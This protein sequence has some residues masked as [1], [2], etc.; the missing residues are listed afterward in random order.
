MHLDFIFFLTDLSCDLCHLNMP[1]ECAVVFPFMLI[2]GSGFW[3]AWV[4][5][6]QSFILNAELE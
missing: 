4:V 3:L 5:H 2:F 6:F 1:V